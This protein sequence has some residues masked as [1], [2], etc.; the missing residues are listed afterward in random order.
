M[1]IEFYAIVLPICV[2]PA[3]LVTLTELNKWS[4]GEKRKSNVVDFNKFVKRKKL[5]DAV[6]SDIAELIDVDRLAA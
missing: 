6:D 2:M 4:E 5:G 3:F 1:S